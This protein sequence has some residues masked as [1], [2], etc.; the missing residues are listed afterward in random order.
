V[1]LT[2]ALAFVMLK[3]YDELTYLRP[4][5]QNIGVKWFMDVL[6]IHLPTL[7]IAILTHSKYI[8]SLSV[9]GFILL[10]STIVLRKTDAP[11]IYAYGSFAY[12]V[13]GLLSLLVYRSRQS[14]HDRF[15]RWL[16]A[17]ARHTCA[18]ETEDTDETDDVNTTGLLHND[19]ATEA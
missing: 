18:I 7:V 19:E 10:A 14:L 12:I 9:L 6:L 15:V 8:F 4:Y 5:E 3:E 16:S 1:I 13:I 11:S 17:C 2:M